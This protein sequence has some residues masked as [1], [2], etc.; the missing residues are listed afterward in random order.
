MMHPIWCA[1]PAV[2]SAYRPTRFVISWNVAAPFF[3]PN[4]SQAS[5]TVAGWYRAKT[6]TPP[7]AL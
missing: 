4:A 6:P 5:R 7:I 1:G 2:A 3:S